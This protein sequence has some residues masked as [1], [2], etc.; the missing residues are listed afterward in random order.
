MS[1]NKNNLRTNFRVFVYGS[2]MWD[3]RDPQFQGTCEGKAILR[4]YH[5]A[6]NKKSTRNWGS[7]ETPCPTLGLEKSGGAEC[8]GL[9]FKFNDNQREEVVAFL[10]DREGSSFQLVE[11]EIELEGGQKEMALTS[12]N[13]S[14]RSTYIGNLCVNKLIEMMQKASGKYGNCIDY[15][16]NLHKKCIELS[17]SDEYVEKVWE[18]IN[19]N[20]EIIK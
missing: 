15:I 7:S 11:V 13:S 19:Q 10:K 5:R 16:Q 9:V 20:F 17:I 6:F 1:E 8:V 18:G 2:L 14:E 12:I 3:N 4:G